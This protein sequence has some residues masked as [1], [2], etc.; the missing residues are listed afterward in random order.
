MEPSRFI[1]SPSGHLIH[2]TSG[3]DAFVPNPLPPLLDISASLIH[4]LSDADRKLGELA[5]FGRVLPN[6]HLLIHP[7][8]RREA[9]LSSRIE[10]TQASLFD[11]YAFEAVQLPLFDHNSDAKE[12]HNYVTA[13]QYGLDRLESLPVSLRLI[14]EVH[15]KLMDGVRCGYQTTGE[16]RRSQN[17]IGPAG[18]TLSEAT[19]VPPPVEQMKEALYLLEEYLYQTSDFPPLIRA[20]MI[21]YQFEAIH[22]FLDGNGRIGRMLIVL[23]LCAWKVLPQ[24]LLYM[25]AYFEKNRAEYYELL[26]AVSQRGDWDAW[27]SFFLRGVTEQSADAVQRAQR[28]MDVQS[29]YRSLLNQ[30]SNSIKM[31]QVLDYAFINPVFSTNRVAAALSLPFSTVQRY[32]VELL[33]MGFIEEVTGGARNRI[34]RANPILQAIDAQF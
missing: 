27:I 2:S 19:F 34:Y 20:A 21:H 5:G 6:P 16:M 3:Y 17:W 25:S 30:S 18:C 23:L 4:T 22:P 12:V 15:E 32:L 14:C 33:H 7:F 24:P 29:H 26:M 31:L 10:G 1:N 11:I 9:V 13:L 8:L 28:L